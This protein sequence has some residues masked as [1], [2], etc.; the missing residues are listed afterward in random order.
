MLQLGGA[1][2]ATE[3]RIA[4]LL[5]VFRQR[6]LRPAAL[7]ARFVHFVDTSAPLERE[8]A[9]RARPRCSPT[10]RARRR[11]A[12][13]SG[14]VRCSSCRASAR[15]R[16]GRRRRP[17]SRTRAGSR[18]CAASSAASPGR[19]AGAVEA[20]A[21]PARRAPRSHDRDR[22]RARSSDAALLFARAAPRRSR[23][24]TCSAAGAPRSSARTSSSASRS[25]PDEIDYLVDAFRA[26]GRDPTDVELM[27]FA[28]ANSEHCRHKIFNADFVIDGEPQERSLFQ[29]IRNTHREAPGR[30]ARRRTA[31]TPP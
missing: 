30:R 23:A 16:P 10:G 31:T 20:A 14:G 6:G 13:S 17:T 19:V 21:L 11:R 9:A 2:A 25:S 29:M 27:M 12:T 26:L 28:Q 18:A 1:R 5:E 4:S 15:S 22:A 24:S 7:S 3:A 8:G